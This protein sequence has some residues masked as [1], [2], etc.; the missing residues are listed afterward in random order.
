MVRNF[1]APLCIF[2]PSLNKQLRKNRSGTSDLTYAGFCILSCVNRLILLSNMS[3]IT[4]A[5]V[6][7]ATS[8]ITEYNSARRAFGKSFKDFR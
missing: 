4:A 8:H 1:P 7:R 6:L 2:L 5:P 3:F